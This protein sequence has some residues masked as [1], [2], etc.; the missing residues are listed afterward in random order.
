MEYGIVFGVGFLLSVA[1]TPAI[2]CL[3]L[4]RR[5]LDLPSDRKV[6]ALPVPLLGGIAVSFSLLGAVLAGITLLEITVDGTLLGAMLGAA[7]LVVL[8][9]ID[10]RRGMS[11]TI[12]LS[13]QI[14]A[15]SLVVFAGG[16]IV[17][18][19]HEPL[20][21]ALS[22]F[23]I[24]GMTNALNLLDNM[25][26]I[27]GGIAVIASGAF[28]V[29]SLL[30]GQTVPAV[31]ALALASAAL[32]YLHY[33][34]P[35]AS[36]FL[37]DTGSMTIGF[38]LAVLGLTIGNGQP[39]P[40]G[41]TM[42]LLVLAYPIFDTTLVTVTRLA[43]GRKIYLGGKD[44]STHRLRTLVGTDSRTALL[45]YGINLA[46]IGTAFLFYFYYTMTAAWIAIVAAAL[47]LV[48]LGVRLNRVPIDVKRPAP[49][50]DRPLRPVAVQTPDRYPVQAAGAKKP[51][52]SGDG[53]PLARE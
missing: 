6:H 16:H 18:I 51:A 4:K 19:P 21:I 38:L 26:G 15:A 29:L 8:G 42:P 36:I 35:P 31:I 22:L 46:L 2:R 34:F 53:F 28:F 43:G 25:D 13:G 33:N 37:G 12:K 49:A 30:S 44:H 11:P 52:V 41:L 23:W 40:I 50:V 1:L 39:S 20:A 27:T 10:D 9:L 5:L 14:F 17:F 3:A 45:V 7:V 32:G 47:A 48:C 24:V